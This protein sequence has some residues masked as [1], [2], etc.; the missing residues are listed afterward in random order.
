[1]KT[2]QGWLTDKEGDCLKNYACGSVLEIGTWHGRSTAILAPAADVVWTV[3]PHDGFNDNK[4]SWYEFL[5]WLAGSDTRNVIPIRST[6]ADAFHLLPPFFD[7]CYID[8]DHSGEAVQHDLDECLRRC[9]GFIGLHDYREACYDVT[10]IVDKA[11]HEDRITEIEVV[12][13]LIIVRKCQ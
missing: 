11:I 12:D 10:G 8:G 13:R 9:T 4:G 2:P 6:F 5:A 1:M 3:D 7:F